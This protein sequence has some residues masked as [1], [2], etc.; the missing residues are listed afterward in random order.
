MHLQLHFAS[1]LETGKTLFKAPT[2][3][4]TF[5]LPGIVF[6]PNKTQ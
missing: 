6:T 1:I 5:T 4:A 3:A 2:V